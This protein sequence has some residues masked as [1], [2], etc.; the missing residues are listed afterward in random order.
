MNARSGPAAQLE[1]ARPDAQF[2]A[3]RVAYLAKEYKLRPRYDR[4]RAR[5]M[6]SAQEA[7]ARLGISEGTLV[8]WTKYGLVRRHAHNDHAYLYEV[9]DDSVPTKH[10]SRW[11]R[12]ADRAAALSQ[13]PDQDVNLQR[14]EL[15]CE[16]R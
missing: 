9:P 7:A 1:E 16:A 12:L 6:L 15:Q 4:L 14:K 5:G 3:L 11:D 10:S 2:T 13:T 8:R